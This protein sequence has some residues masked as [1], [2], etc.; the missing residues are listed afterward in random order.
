MTNKEYLIKYFFE[1]EDFLMETIDCAVCRAVGLDNYCRATNQLS[2][3]DTKKQWLSMER[4]PLN[5][6][7]GDVVEVLYLA[8]TILRYYAGNELSYYYFVSSREEIE[9]IKKHGLRSI[10]KQCCLLFTASQL[11]SLVRKVGEVND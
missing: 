6:K 7:V 8:T 3:D 4:N 2:C 5:L 9:Q 1:H 11:E 10:S